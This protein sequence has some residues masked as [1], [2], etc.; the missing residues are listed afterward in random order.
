[1]ELV[2]NQRNVIEKNDGNASPPV[3]IL[4]VVMWGPWGRGNT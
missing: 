3:A 4:A 1:M 2:K